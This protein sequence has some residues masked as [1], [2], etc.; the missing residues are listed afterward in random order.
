MYCVRNIQVDKA[1]K[2]YDWCADVCLAS[3]HLYN[4]TLFRVRQCMTGLS[5]AKED[6]FP[7]EQEVLDEIETNLPAMN[8]LS[9]QV[10]YE[11]PTADKWMLSY[12]FLDALFK[13]TSNPDYRYSGI[14]AHG[15]QHTI[16]Q[17][18]QDMKS[19]FKANNDY[20]EHPVKYTGRPKPPK[21]KKKQSLSTIT[22]SN[23]ECSY[24]PKEKAFRLPKTKLRLFAGD[25]D[26]DTHSL[27]EVRVIPHHDVFTIALVLET[28]DL[29]QEVGESIRIASVDLGGDNFAAITTNTGDKSLLVKGGAIKDLVN[30]TNR[31]LQAFQMGQ[32]GRSHTYFVSTK[33]SNACMLKQHN[34]IKDLVRKTAKHVV[35]WLVENQIDTLIVG[36]NVYQKQKLSLGK[37]NNGNFYP[38]PFT[39]FRNQLEYR[40]KQV[41]ITYLETEES[42]TSKSSFL[43]QDILPA[44][45]GTHK[46]Y[47]FSGKRFKRGLYKSQDGTIINADL[48]GAANIGRKLFPEKFLPNFVNFDMDVFR[49]CA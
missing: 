37:K 28:S 34:R 30:Q 26:F 47:C 16:K 35:D 4:A 3:T 41:G 38:L 22:I 11:M 7:L 17:V 6:R 24:I 13:V 8:A 25:I 40:C 5:K 19:Y 48:N 49:P 39:Y 10:S 20:K 42:Y 23:I 32:C 33:R 27:K 1:N 2:L 31:R 46:N 18:C 15:A 43:D 14:S 36:H 29:E 21:Y 12:N 9:K 44:F 45:D